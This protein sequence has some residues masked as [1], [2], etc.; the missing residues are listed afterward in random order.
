[1]AEAEEVT[2]KIETRR[3]LEEMDKGE[4]KEPKRSIKQAQRC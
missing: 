1:M 4:A 3:G 2:T